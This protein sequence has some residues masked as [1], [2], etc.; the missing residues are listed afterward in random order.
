[1]K[2]D[3]FSGE[4]RF[5]SN[6][7]P[8]IVQYD[9]ILYPTNEHAFQAAKTV[10]FDERLLIPGIETPG[11][12]KK[13]GKLLT[14]RD[15]WDVLRQQIM[16]DLCILKFAAHKELRKK[17]LDTNGQELIEGNNWHDNWWGNCD[18]PKCFKIKGENYLG[19]ILMFVRDKVFR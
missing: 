11:Q 5:L 14:L 12:A 8:A 18:C 4:Y 15:N 19:S 16:M 13:R 9:G 3:S 10:N 7:Y 1:M 17:L 6:F 2:I